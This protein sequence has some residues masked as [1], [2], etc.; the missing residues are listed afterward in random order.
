MR[1][2]TG[3]NF[4]ATPLHSLIPYVVIF[5]ALGALLY[6][7]RNR[8]P[9][10]QGRYK[11]RDFLSPA[12]KE[13]F[14]IL[15]AAVPELHV[16]PQVSMGAIMESTSSMNS[17]DEVVRRKALGEWSSVRSNRIDFCLVDAGLELKCLVELDD[18]SHASPAAKKK[19]RDRDARAAEAG[20]KTVRFG[21]VAGKLP[22]SAQ[23]RAR[24]EAEFPD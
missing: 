6:G 10:D 18:R 20:Y 19:D 22:S 9:K 4:V 15:S 2:T 13:F 14:A 24:L 11:A 7:W 21:W 16:F 17:R 5:L 3:S 1:Y 23:V 12:E 8:K